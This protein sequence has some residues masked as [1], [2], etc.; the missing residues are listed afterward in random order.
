MEYSA[1]HSID[2]S[3]VD[4]PGGHI[5][6]LQRIGRKRYLS[7]MP[8]SQLRQ[9]V[10][11]PRRAE[12]RRRV[13]HATADERQQA[14]LRNEIQRGFRGA[15]QQNA[16]EYARYLAMVLNG[17]RDE[18]WS[19]PVFCLWMLGDLNVHGASQVQNLLP[20]QLVGR[21]PFGNL[22]ILLDG[23]TQHVAHLLLQENPEDYGLES[24]QVGDR[25][26]GVE[27]HH[28][29][30]VREARQIFHD[31]NRLGVTASK[32]VGLSSD[33]FDPTTSISHFLRETVKVNTRL[34]EE[35]VP[36]S[37]LVAT[38]TDQVKGSA[39]Q[40]MTF[41]SL[42]SF[43]ATA[44]FGRSAVR[45]SKAI[46]RLPTGCHQEVAQKALAEAAELLF[47]FFADEF[48]RRSDSVIAA[49]A[50]LAGLG[51]VLHGA[52]PWNLSGNY[53]LDE[54]VM[55]LADINWDR[56]PG[57]WQGVMGKVVV[58]AATGA[59]SLS[60]AGGIHEDGLRVSTALTDRNSPMFTQIRRPAS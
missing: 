56:D 9:I 30:T 49:P 48:D 7:S 57:V 14:E 35:P 10:P 27:I 13:E 41:S 39:T 19:T 58:D 43:V 23:E 18:G 42:H 12:G 50:V 17:E 38:S 54:A 22:G 59:R 53:S 60:M 40:W 52:M 1:V 29:L 2:G 45:G 36:F 16:R 6:P 11:D 44:I 26:V 15:K 21:T 4:V 31:R 37:R 25:M 32:S 47:G 3:Q 8:W 33:S 55:L 20:R 46:V 51:V 5:L 24:R 28:D 34:P